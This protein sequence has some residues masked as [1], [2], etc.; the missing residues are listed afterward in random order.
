MRTRRDGIS[1]NR[2]QVD[3]GECIDDYL[4]FMRFQGEELKNDT[5]HVLNLSEKNGCLWTECG[6]LVLQASLAER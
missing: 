1:G 3:H 5:A 2:K 6:K 4:M